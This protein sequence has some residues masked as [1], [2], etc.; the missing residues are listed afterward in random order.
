MQAACTGS[1]YNHRVP[2]NG[3]YREHCMK[4]TN[5]PAGAKIRSIIEDKFHIHD[6]HP[7]FDRKYSDPV[8]AN[9]YAAHLIKPVYREGWTLPELPKL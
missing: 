1:G 4:F 3:R 9:E 8:D 2:H 7:T 6:G 5:I